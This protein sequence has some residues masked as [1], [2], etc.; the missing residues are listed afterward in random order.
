MHGP[1][2]PLACSCTW[3]GDDS[4][5]EASDCVTYDT[6]QAAMI[7]EPR[8]GFHVSMLRKLQVT[9]PQEE[10][11]R[12]LSEFKLNTHYNATNQKLDAISYTFTCCKAQ[13]TNRT[14]MRSRTLVDGEQIVDF[15]DKYNVTEAVMLFHNPDF[16]VR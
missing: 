14:Y 4:G 5:F 12:L 9:C 8:E 7:D 15:V 1:P 16:K 6:P 11:G 3:P 2:T 13:D 10:Q